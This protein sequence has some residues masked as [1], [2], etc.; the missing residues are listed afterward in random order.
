M[1]LVEAHIDIIKE[2]MKSYLNISKKNVLDLV[3]K[4]VMYFL[5]NHAKDNIQNELVR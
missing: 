3:P 4:T 1:A 2:L 5:V